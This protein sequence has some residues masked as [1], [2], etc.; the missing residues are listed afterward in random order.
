MMVVGDE[1]LAENATIRFHFA[2]ERA[3]DGHELPT[4]VVDLGGHLV[5]EQ[6]FETREIGVVGAEHLA[7]SAA[8]TTSVCQREKRTLQGVRRAVDRGEIVDSDGVA[9]L[10][11]DGNELPDQ[12]TLRVENV[13][14]V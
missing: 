9:L 4:R 1:G 8:A 14:Q 2:G 11:Q 5:A 13:G 3:G 7:D 10:K 12:A 6:G